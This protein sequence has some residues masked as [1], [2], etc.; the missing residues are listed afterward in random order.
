[1]AKHIQLRLI[2]FYK[3][4]LGQKLMQ[5]TPKILQ[6]CM[7]LGAKWGA[8]AGRKVLEDYKNKPTADQEAPPILEDR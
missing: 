1:M 6:E 2:A 3:T 5:E 4:P 8:E 7:E